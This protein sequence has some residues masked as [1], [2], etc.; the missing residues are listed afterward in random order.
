[1]LAPEHPLVDQITT[2]EQK[3]EVEEYRKQAAAK[4][5]L[6][7]TDLA[8]EK[9][10]VWTG[11]YAHQSRH[12]KK[13]PHLD[14]RL[15]LMGYGTGAVMGVPAHDERDFEFAK[16]YRSP[17]LPVIDPIYDPGSS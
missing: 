2:L 17:D 15:C 11:A 9:T 14:C 8:K 6:E 4:S 10:G 5:D 13:N 7:R 16:K 12:R 3:D 1:M